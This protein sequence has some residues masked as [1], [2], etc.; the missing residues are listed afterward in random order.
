MDKLIRAPF[1]H[2]VHRW[3][4]AL[5]SPREGVIV[6]ALAT[7]GERSRTDA[8]AQIRLAV[9]QMLGPLL[10][11]TPEQIILNSM[12]GHAP[13]IAIDA[14]GAPVQG[15]GSGSRCSIGLSISHEAGLSLA[16]INLHG[17]IGVDLMRVPQA[18]GSDNWNDLLLLARDYLAPACAAALVDVA[19]QL[20]H[21]AF[22]S[23]WT[24][25]EASLKCRGLVLA[26]WHSAPPVSASLAA[27]RIVTL[28]LPAPFVGTVAIPDGQLHRA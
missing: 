1:K 17:P 7:E 4:G 12:P 19:P 10:G 13:V 26:E 6:I 8:R 5:P 9:R 27:L 22:A 28:D 3:P 14:D 18:S 24:A 20:R 2:A 25:H 16:A 11:L 21:S 15:S 23:A